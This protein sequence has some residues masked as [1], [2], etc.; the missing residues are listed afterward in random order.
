MA[1]NVLAE[2]EIW[3][4]LRV[5]TSWLD[6]YHLLHPAIERLF[7]VTLF[8]VSWWR[9]TARVTRSARFRLPP[10]PN[11]GFGLGLLQ[12]DRAHIPNFWIG[13]AQFSP[14]ISKG[15]EDSD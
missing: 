13:L 1:R 7:H 5:L 11:T 15:N 10:R 8:A 9:H 2:Q 14:S 3:S 4:N 6:A 12:F